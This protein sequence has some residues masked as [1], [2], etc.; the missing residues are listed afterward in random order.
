MPSRRALLALTVSP[1]MARRASAQAA[2]HRLV[3]PFPP[4]GSMETAARQMIPAVQ[5]EIGQMVVIEN[6]PGGGTVIGTEA[7]SRAAPD[8][9]TSLMVAN[10]FLIKG[11]MQPNPAYDP[12]RDFQPI[13]LIAS[14]PHVLAATPAVASDFTGF[15]SAARRPGRGLSFGSY[16]HGSASHL[17]AAQLKILARLN[18]QHVPY[19]GAAQ[20]YNGLFTGRVD[21][22]FMHESDVA[23][24]LRAGQIRPLAIAAPLRS[25]RM[26]EIP[27][28]AELGFGEVLSESW[29]GV[30]APAAVPTPIAA[31]LSA[32]WLAALAKRDV[33]A[34][35][36]DQAFSILGLGAEEF[37]AR[38]RR[39]FETYAA[40]IRTANLRAE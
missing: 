37:G 14:V 1:I 16:G 29:F 19:R 22:M 7:V 34:R 28:L 27:T 33:A 18:A 3:I 35:L 11:A 36:A 8:G 13:A 5:A 24:P 23:Q 12:L 21:F 25:P 20:A 39:D 17:G 15:L 10:A 4:G 32:A 31:R 26:P 30:V 2:I 6:R 40:V 9:Q 38:L